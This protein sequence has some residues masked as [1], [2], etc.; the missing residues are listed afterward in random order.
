VFEAVQ[1]N[2]KVL[3]KQVSGKSENFK[4]LADTGDLKMGPF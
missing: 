4:Y 3:L 1:F 2:A